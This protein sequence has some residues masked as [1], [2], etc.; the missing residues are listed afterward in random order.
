MQTNPKVSIIITTLDNSALTLDCVNS[1]VDNTKSCLHEIIVVD[2]GSAATEL[3]KLVQASDGRF[4]VVSLNRN[5]FFGEA[6]NIGAEHA[7]ADYIVFLNNDARV[8]PGWLDQLLMTLASEVYAGAVGPKFL[9]PNGTLQEAGAYIR[10]DGW[11]VQMGKCDMKLP[12]AY[13]DTTRVA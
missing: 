9:Y 13:A 1:V 6:N 10:P 2:N 5:L 7:S 4:N 12:P 3:E 8:T 11:G